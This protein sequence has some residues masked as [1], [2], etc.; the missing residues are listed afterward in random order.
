MWQ[1]SSGELS[2]ATSSPETPGDSDLNDQIS[3]HLLPATSLSSSQPP[4][5]PSH[6][7]SVN[8]G[9][10]FKLQPLAEMEMIGACKRGRPRGRRNR[11]AAERISEAAQRRDSKNSR[12]RQRV[13]NVK[14]EYARLQQMLGLTELKSDSKEHKRHCK[15]RTLTAAIERIR[16][17]MAID[18]LTSREERISIEVKE[19][20]QQQ[21]RGEDGHSEEQ[22]RTG[23]QPN[24][25]K[26]L[27][28]VKIL[29]KCL[30]L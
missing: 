4:L 22:R 20:L 25:V 28:Q 8:A 29:V 7:I 30:A 17:L 3:V 2:P 9:P 12:E 18:Q 23:P 19:S 15:F 10:S 13:G 26:R 27:I 14:N 5:Q 6:S 24:V 1:N 21:Q 16:T 11:T